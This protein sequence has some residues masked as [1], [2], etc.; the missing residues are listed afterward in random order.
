M[1][2]ATVYLLDDEIMTDVMKVEVVAG[3]VRLSSMFEASRLVAATI[4]D[5]DLMRHVVLLEPLGDTQK[6]R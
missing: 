2:Q 3:G 1:C 6:T 4:R 5:I